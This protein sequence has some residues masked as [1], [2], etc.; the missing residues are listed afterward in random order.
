[1]FHLSSWLIPIVC[2]PR[3][4]DAD[5]DLASYIAETDAMKGTFTKIDPHAD[6]VNRKA[7]IHI[8][9]ISPQAPEKTIRDFFVFCGKI[10]N[11]DLKQSDDRQDQECLILFEKESAARTATMLTNAMILGRPIKV[12]LYSEEAVQELVVN[13]PQPLHRQADAPTTAQVSKLA[14][15]IA[16]SLANF[17]QVLQALLKF[18]QKYGFTRVAMRVAAPAVYVDR[19]LGVSD[20]VIN[21]AIELAE[22]FMVEQ[23]LTDLKDAAVLYTNAALTT[24]VGQQVEPYFELAKRVGVESFSLLQRRLA[25]QQNVHHT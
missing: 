5:I 13:S 20:K 3:N 23:R 14:E 2:S 17:Y 11:L 9:Q 25:K 16:S 10:S 19:K 15:L 8:T 12:E 21:T 1:M 7:L 18:D 6:S 4:G 24:S 22:Y